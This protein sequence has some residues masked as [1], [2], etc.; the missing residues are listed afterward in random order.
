MVLRKRNKLSNQGGTSLVELMIACLVLIVGV[1]GCAALIPLA[2]GTNFRNRQ[3]S[4]ST[5]IAQMVMEKV[6]S[7]PAGTNPVLAITDCTN[8]ANNVNTAGSAGAGSGAPLLASGDVNFNV[9]APPG[10]GMLYTTCGTAGRQFVY[11]VRWNIQTPST[12][13][14][15]I[16]VSAKLR[17]AG[18]DLKYFSF[19][20]TIRSMAGQ[21]S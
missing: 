19:P 15:L 12:Y 18:N 20:V 16:T 11:D 8:T 4:N 1:A 14:K 6:L 21:G 10:Y 17:G 7:V 2:I 5:V 13:V 9:A 3:Q